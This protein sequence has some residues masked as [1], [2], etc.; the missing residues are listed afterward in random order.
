[1]SVSQE[2]DL[3]AA[4]MKQTEALK[5]QTEAINR[6]A[7]TNTKLCELLIQSLDDDIEEPEVVLKYLGDKL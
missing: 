1:M 6:L 7:E 4:L 2:Q 3:I 5:A